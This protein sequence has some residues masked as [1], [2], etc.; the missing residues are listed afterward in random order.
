MRISR[1]VHQEHATEKI[2]ILPEQK[3]RSTNARHK[4]HGQKSPKRPTIMSYSS[5]VGVHPWGQGEGVKGRL[6]R[7]SP[8]YGVSCCC[9]RK[10]ALSLLREKYLRKTHEKQNE[11]DKRKTL[12]ALPLFSAIE[13]T[14][15]RESLAAGKIPASKAHLYKYWRKT[16]RDVESGAE[17]VR[18]AIPSTTGFVRG[19]LSH[20]VSFF[21]LPR[22][23]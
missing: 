17:C 7:K 15:K 6:V 3:A 21:H 18:R 23:F 1:H 10:Q 14:L 5:A 20:S 13:T 16:E 12:P 11:E 8:Q 9:V 19:P 22:F 4:R 2:H